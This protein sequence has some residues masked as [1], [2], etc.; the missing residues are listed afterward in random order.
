MARNIRNTLL[1]IFFALR[2]KKREQHINTK[3]TFYEISNIEERKRY[4][5]VGRKSL[6]I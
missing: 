1:S 4:M 5:V 3:P 6:R 2:G